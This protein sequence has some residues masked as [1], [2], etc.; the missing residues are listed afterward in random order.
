M[1][2]LEQRIYEEAKRDH[3][4]VV[5][6]RRHFHRY[7]ELSAK[8][9]N[10][11][12]K[13][14]E[15]LDNIGVSHQRIGETGVFAEIKGSLPGN[16]TIV[17]RADIDA[18]AIEEQHI[19]D[20]SSKIKGVMHACGHDAHAACL[21]GA[22][23]ILNNHRDWFGGTVRLAFQQ[24]EEIGYGAKIFIEQGCLKNA[25]R[26]FGIHVASN[27]DKGSVVAMEG[28]NN[29]SVDWF[30]I[31]VEGKPAHVSTPERGVDAAYI[32]SQIVVSLQ[33]LIT[34]RTSPMDN[35]LIGIGKINAGTAYNIVAQRA[36][37]EGTIRV[38][39]PEI[40]RETKENLENLA[41]SVAS[42]YGGSAFVE[43][44]DFTSP[45]INDKTATREAQAVAAS[46]LGRDKV[47]LKRS[48]SLGGD[49]FAEFILQAP[50]VYVF[51]GSRN[52]ERFE[53][54][55]AHHNSYFDIDEESLL[56]GTAMYACYTVEY[57]N[58][59]IKYEE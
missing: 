58:D 12:L 13:I 29:A 33:A 34:R 11:A 18:L 31:T 24:G 16:K 1:N 30:K 5:S 10:T 42:V 56:V 6:L 3:E 22:A 51:V 21:L 20:Y 28:P 4:Y 53:T 59:E 35:V 25:D 49:D 48:P 57:L 15:E 52:E 55:V 19:S 47:I 27:V 36:E 43:W 50:G 17:L 32:A 39:T 38:F 7:P 9:Y 40:R 45:L 2:E 26:C 44:K 41:K 8:E 14:E 46:L 37:L 23:R 54:T